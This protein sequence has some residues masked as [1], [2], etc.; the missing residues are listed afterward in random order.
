MNRNGGRGRSLKYKSSQ[1]KH[2]I[3]AKA[4]LAF[5]VVS[6]G[7]SAIPAATPAVSASGVKG[8]EKLVFFHDVHAE[9]WS[10]RYVSKA[11]LLGIVQGD[12]NG[13]FR[14][15]DSITKQEAVTMALRFAG[16]NASAS[17]TPP[18][19]VDGWAQ[20]LVAAA[21][22]NGL[23]K[24][25]EETGAGNWGREPATREWITRLA[26]RAI[27]KD[28]EA[29]L[30]G[31]DPGSLPDFSDS[32][33]ISEWARG[34]VSAAAKLKIVNGFPD[35]S[36][37]PQTVV[38]RAQLAALLSE[39]EIYTE[40]TDKVT[41]GIVEA[42]DGKTVRIAKETGGTETFTLHGSAVFIGGSSSFRVGLPV[43]I[44]HTGTTALFAE[45]SAQQK[46]E[47]IAGPTGATGTFI[48]GKQTSVKNAVL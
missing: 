23:L 46:I 25:D 32:G 35:Q 15:N 45:V 38:T 42:F 2:S 6:Q 40:R 27:S 18:V 9:M 1:E 13:A 29:Q 37:K 44:V 24:E 12:G 34:Y 10:Y 33:S 11:A 16:I 14:P 28:A 3:Y 21:F 19:Q 48:L 43:V 4:S 47:W 39:A 31:A 26:V 8:S 7:V 5:L 17:G 22:D 41:R 36:F 30:L 20:A